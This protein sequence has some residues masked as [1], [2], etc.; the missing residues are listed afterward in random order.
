MMYVTLERGVHTIV[1]VKNL[2]V[3]PVQYVMSACC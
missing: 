1:S 3:R 2:C